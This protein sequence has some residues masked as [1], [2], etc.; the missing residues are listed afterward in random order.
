[1]KKTPTRFVRG[2]QFKLYEDGRLF[3]VSIDPLEEN[4]LDTLSQ[5][6]QSAKGRLQAAL[7]LMPAW[8]KPAPASR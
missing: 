3:D 2:K 6:Q 5:D 7:D 8:Q 1:M 4:A